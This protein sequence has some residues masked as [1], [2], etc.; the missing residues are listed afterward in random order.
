MDG[1]GGYERKELESGKSECFKTHEEHQKRII[2]V[3]V[4]YLS[5]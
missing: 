2:R 4:V 5:P 3:R 1:E